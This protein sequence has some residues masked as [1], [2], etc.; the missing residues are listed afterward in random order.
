MA[1]ADSVHSTPPTNMSATAAHRPAIGDVPMKAPGCAWEFSGGAIGLSTSL[2]VFD[3]GIAAG[4]A[5]DLSNSERAALADYM[6]TLWTRFR[7][8]NHFVTN[9]TYPTAVENDV[10]ANRDALAKQF[11]DVESDVRDLCRAVKVVSSVI[12]DQLADP[13]GGAPVTSDYGLEVQTFYIDADMLRFAVDHATELALA[14]S[15]KMQ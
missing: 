5:S 7:D 4:H 12:T 3:G 13:I 9:L 14:V 8:E 11:L 1:K 6:M 10:Q 15:H 2:C